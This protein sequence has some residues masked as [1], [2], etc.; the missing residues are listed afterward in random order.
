MSVGTIR[1]AGIC[2]TLLESIKNNCSLLP[3]VMCIANS[4]YLLFL[5]LQVILCIN[6]DM[7]CYMTCYILSSLFL[8][9]V[10]LNQWINRI[11]KSQSYFIY[12][13]CDTRYDWVQHRFVHH[14]RVYP[15]QSDW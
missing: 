8:P 12:K 3:C 2:I 4:W 6:I 7:L 14:C 1:L 13:W 10:A 5:H 9:V 11:I 15:K